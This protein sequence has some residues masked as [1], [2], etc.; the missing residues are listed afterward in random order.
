MVFRRPQSTLRIYFFIFWAGLIF[1]P[2][3][4][5]GDEAGATKL[6]FYSSNSIVAVVD[7][8]PIKFDELKDAGIQQTLVRLYKQRDSILKQKILDRVIK[9]HPELGRIKVPRVDEKDVRK[10]YQNTPGVKEIGPFEQMA[11]EI[12][13]FIKISLRQKYVDKIYQQAIGKGWVV[14]Y[15]TP[16]NDFRVIAIVGSAALMFP[17]E[18]DRE[19]RQV[20]FLEYSDFQCPFCK[21]VQGAIAKLRKQYSRTVQFAYRHF[22]LPFH[23]EAGKMAEA[24]EC[25]RDQG[26][27]WEMQSLLY[28]KELASINGSQASDLAR[29][30]GVRDLNSFQD[31]WAKRKYRQ[32]VEDDVKEGASIGVQGTPSFIIGVYDPGKDAIS[33][34][35]L[36]GALEEAKFVEVIEKFLKIAKN[37]SDR[38]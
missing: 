9:N 26:R 17:P 23:T 13:Q 32:R 36:S 1:L 16:P 8:E 25:A 27:F 28:K 38:E 18:N 19:K 35:M 33:G 22:P 2:A 37:E 12:R 10:F 24:A 7:G 21:R 14:N 6:P 31:C 15:L 30:A 4:S 20:F 29:Q 3:V 5:S 11:P 34:E